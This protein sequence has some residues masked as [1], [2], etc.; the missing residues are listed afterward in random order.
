V[1]DV[2]NGALSPALMARITNSGLNQF[3][4]AS[5]SNQLWKGEIQGYNGVDFVRTP[6]AFRLSVPATLGAITLTAAATEGAESLSVSFATGGGKT[7]PAGYAFTVP[8]VNAVDVFGLDTGEPRVF[9]ALEDVTLAGAAGAPGTGTITV[10]PIH[11]TG[12]KKNATSLPA[13]TTA[14]KILEDGAAYLT[15]AVFANKAVAFAS[16]GVKPMPGTESSTSNL[17]GEV[18]VRMSLDSAI[19]DGKSICRWDVLAGVKSLYGIGACAIYA[20]A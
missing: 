19:T 16:T 5:V 15:G 14:N 4:E 7:V 18:N 6:D 3:G 8:G 9:I 1:G 10:A 20:K 2:I 11:A 12:A 17:E 13:A